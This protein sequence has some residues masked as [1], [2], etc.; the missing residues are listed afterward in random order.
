[1]QIFLNG[2]Q[3]DGVLTEGAALP[4]EAADLSGDLYRL[5]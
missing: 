5:R 1:M 3:F 2:G 4:I